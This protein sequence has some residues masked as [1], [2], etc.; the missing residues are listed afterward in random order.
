MNRAR[1]TVAI[2]VVNYRTPS[3]TLRC[4]ASLE[5]LRYPSWFLIVVDN[6]SGDGSADILRRALG[7]RVV[8]EAP[9][10][11]GYTAGNN[12]GI[13]IALARGAQF[14]HVLNPDVTVHNPDY[15]DE[16]VDF[17]EQSPDFG[18][19]GPKVY[20]RSVSVHQNTVLRFP[21]V[22][23]RVKDWARSRLGSKRAPIDH[24]VEAEAL[25][26]VCVLFRAACL[27]DVG[28]FDEATFAY[29][30]D[31][32]WAYRAKAMGWRCAYRPIPSIV[33]HQAPRGYERGGRV[34]FLLKRNT[35]YFLLKSG[36]WLQGAAY[37]VATLALAWGL[38]MSRLPCW[39]DWREGRRFAT[40]LASTYAALFSSRGAEVM[41]PPPW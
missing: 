33:H 24:P 36:R 32:D 16:L 37:A 40:R 6:A 9:G 19:V 23:R 13:N 15:L 1:P 29:I 11:G 30:E 21:W 3:D 20:L 28:L 35:L 22:A 27:R 18:A 38:A 31:L 12:L 7:E 41:G 2:V 26:G 39:R 8:F 4:C 5:R 25:N 34:D 17:L 14:V 10:N